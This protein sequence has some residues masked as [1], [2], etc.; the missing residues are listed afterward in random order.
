ILKIPLNFCSKKDGTQA[1]LKRGDKTVG[2][3]PACLLLCCPRYMINC[4]PVTLKNN[5][6]NI[7]I[8]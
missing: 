4:K 7:I 8:S 2:I 1:G 6:S 3:C 5:E